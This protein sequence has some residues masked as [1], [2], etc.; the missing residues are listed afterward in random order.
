MRTQLDFPEDYDGANLAPS[1]MVLTS[2]RTCKRLEK[3][4]AF[5]FSMAGMSPHYGGAG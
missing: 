5:Y 2:E 1:V 4:N 3:M